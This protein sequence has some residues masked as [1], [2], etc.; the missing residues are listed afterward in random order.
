VGEG[1]FFFSFSPFPLRFVEDIEGHEGVEG[2]VTTK[3]ADEDLNSFTAKRKKEQ[4]K[5]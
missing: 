3:V 5:M 4:K 1:D 2:R